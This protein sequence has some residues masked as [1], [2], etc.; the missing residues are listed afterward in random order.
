MIFISDEIEKAF[1]KH[2][3]IPLMEYPRDDLMKLVL[4]IQQIF[5]C[6]DL[7]DDKIGD[8]FVINAGY[9]LKDVSQLTLFVF[10]DQ[11][12]LQASPD[13]PIV[14]V[15]SVT[16]FMRDT[17]GHAFTVDGFHDEVTFG[18]FDENADETILHLMTKLYAPLILKDKQW[19]DNIKTRLFTDLHSFM[20]TLTDVSSKVGHM[21]ILY[22]PNE[23]LDMP[24]E[25]AAS[26]KALVKRYE[27]VLIQHWT[28]QI[29]TCL[30]E[31]QNLQYTLESPA[32]E[33]EFW[34]YKCELL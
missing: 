9:W 22:I 28:S 31:V 12:V 33:H 11:G 34:V 10:F 14:P 20:A 24:V 23:S 17:P 32:D 5:T 29:R 3:T 18:T 16:Y 21:V 13:C 19:N 1:E 30:N 15:T 25:E 7:A 27:S 6:F 26:D 2:Q 8:S 4:Y